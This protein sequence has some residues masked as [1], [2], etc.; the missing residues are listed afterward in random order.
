MP[1]KVTVTGH[2]LV[3]SPERDRV[4]KMD[5][6]VFFTLDGDTKNP[7]YVRLADET[8]TETLERRAI[9]TYIA[10]MKYPKPREFSVG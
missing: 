10:S 9:E 6:F 4:G 5:R 8:W 7:H 3:L 1:V 2:R